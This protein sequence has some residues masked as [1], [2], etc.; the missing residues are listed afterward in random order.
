MGRPEWGH[1]LRDRSRNGIRNCR[2]GDREVGNGWTV[3]K[4][5]VIKNY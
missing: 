4:I 3:K 5:K 2:E 1:P